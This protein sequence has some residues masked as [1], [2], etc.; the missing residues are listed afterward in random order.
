MVAT[1]RPSSL[2]PK[3]DVTLRYA[4]GAEEALLGALVAELTGGGGGGE[5]PARREGWDQVR[6]AADPDG[7]LGPA[8]LAERAGASRDA[9]AEAAARLRRNGPVVV[10]WGERLADGERATQAVRALLALTRALDLGG[11]DGA[12]M[13]GIPAGSNGRGLRE[14]GCLPNMKAGLV[15]AEAV[16]LDAAGIARALG[17][18]VSALV[19]LQADPL[20]TH[21]D[22][23]DWEEGLGRAA[24]VI[25]FSDFRTETVAEHADV[26]FPAQVY[27][28]KEGTVT[29]PDGRLQRLRTSVA[30]PEL[31]RPQVDVLLELISALSGAPFRLSPPQLTSFYADTIPFYRGLTVD[32]IGGRGVRWQERDAAGQLAQTPLPD[33][34]LEDPPELPDGMRLGTVPS[35]WASRETDHADAL[36]FLAPTQRAELSAAD[37]RRLGI[38]PGDRVEVAVDGTSVRAVAALRSAVPA[39]TVFLIEGTSEDNANALANGRPRTVEVRKA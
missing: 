28:E 9:I 38:E 36:R 32:E 11:D 12:G 20:R 13:I 19:L 10:L 8:A 34:D 17:G 29:H 31:V 6:F 14:V 5:A 24:S 26:V 37:A 33:T 4:P 18:D 25:A 23:G 15:D 1:S 7:G 16:G 39:G 35:L 2:D 22:R 27:A 3:A 21:P 30:M